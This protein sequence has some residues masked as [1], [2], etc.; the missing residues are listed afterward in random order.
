MLMTGLSALFVFYFWLT[1]LSFYL[2]LF[3]FLHPALLVL[4]SI[5]ASSSVVVVVIIIIIIIIIIH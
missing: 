3:Y 5:A 4:F 2:T 1:S